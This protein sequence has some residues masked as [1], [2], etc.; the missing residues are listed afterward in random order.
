[1]PKVAVGLHNHSNFSDGRFSPEDLLEGGRARDYEFFAITDHNSIE[2][3]RRLGPL[4]SWA[5]PG[6]ELSVISEHSQEVHLL[7]LGVEARGPLL[8]HSRRFQELY[9]AIWSEGLATLADGDKGILDLAL[10]PGRRDACIRA[11]SARI[12][13]AAAMRTWAAIH[14]RVYEQEL[15]P[16]MP[17]LTQGIGMLRESGA[18]IGLAHPHR[19]TRLGDLDNI[20]D[21]VDAVEAIHPSHDSEQEAH[22]RAVARD[23]GKAT[24]GSHDFHG[25][26]PSQRA[27]M[28]EP[29]SLDTRDIDFI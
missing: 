29:I 16:L 13:S 18:R 20:I 19:Y 26:S 5:I 10:D 27:G 11:L 28:L 24:W 21:S 25:W 4:P 6:I 23:R 15:R 17:S 14:S 7:G 9:D 8:E 12:A 22:W 2:G 3:W 1:M